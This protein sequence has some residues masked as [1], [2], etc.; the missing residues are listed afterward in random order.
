MWLEELVQLLPMLLNTGKAVLSKGGSSNL[1]DIVL[2]LANL[3]VVNSL[4]GIINYKIFLTKTISVIG[5]K[6][7]SST[8]A[9]DNYRK[10]S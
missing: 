1:L 2:P 9:T 4:K 8:D 7:H 3:S 6:M 5:G 10:A